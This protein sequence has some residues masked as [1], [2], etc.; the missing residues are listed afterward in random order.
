[1]PRKELGA[2]VIGSIERKTLH[3][4]VSGSFRCFSDSQCNLARIRKGADSLS[5]YEAH[6]I[7]QILENTR[8]N[9]WSYVNTKENPADILSRGAVLGRLMSKQKQISWFELDKLPSEPIRICAIKLVPFAS[10]PSIDKKLCVAEFGKLLKT[11][12]LIMATI[13]RR[14]EYSHRPGVK[15]SLAQITFNKTIALIQRTLLPLTYKRALESKSPYPNE[16]SRLRNKSVILD[17]SGVLRLGSRVTEILELEQD[18]LSYEQIHK[19]IMPDHAITKSFVVYLHRHEL[20]HARRP[21]LL[22]YLQKY[23][24]INGVTSIVRMVLDECT[25]CR[26][27]LSSPFRTP[28]AHLPLERVQP[29]RAF[30]RVGLDLFGPIVLTNL[31]KTYGL[32]LVCTTSRAIHLELVEDKSTEAVKN[33]LHRFISR[34]GLPAY[35]NSDNEKSFR[36]LNWIYRSFFSILTQVRGQIIRESPIQWT[37]NA[38]YAP[39]EGGHYERLIRS[40][41]AVLSQF[42]PQTFKTFWCLSTIL[43]QVEAFVNARPLCKLND[44]NDYLTPMHL[45]TGFAP[46][47]LRCA[48][49]NPRMTRVS[50]WI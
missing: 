7:R 39:W 34:R 16:S 8:A 37:F 33:A 50:I 6:R 30:Y 44:A 2:A 1:M 9:E 20:F 38:A 14:F 41:K 3:N 48:D 21:R 5:A 15:N 23:Y 31:E 47:S 11:L 25:R 29:V 49:Q 35:I 22:A 32:I 18:W 28:M 17:R 26:R 19:I 4:I 12:K 27:F 24:G 36:K 10:D 43:T 42:N 45:V 13:D 46:T 40:V